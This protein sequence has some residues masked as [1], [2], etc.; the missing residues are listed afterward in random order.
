MQMTSVRQYMSIS[1][2]RLQL[3]HVTT[4]LYL[5]LSPGKSCGLLTCIQT[6]AAASD[7]R[8]TITCHGICYEVFLIKLYNLATHSY[9][10]FTCV[11]VHLGAQLPEN[12]PSCAIHVHTLNVDAKLC[13]CE[14]ISM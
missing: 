12:M 14:G 6:V 13:R 1:P 4:V 9:M 5:Y 7:Q 11:F 2:V 10:L 3:S 8:N